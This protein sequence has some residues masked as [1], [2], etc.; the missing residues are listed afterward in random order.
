MTDTATPLINHPFRPLVGER[1]NYCVHR[2]NEFD[3]D[4]GEPYER[5]I[6]SVMWNGVHRIGTLP[7]QS[8]PI[9]TLHQKKV[10][11]RMIRIDGPFE[12][13]TKEGRLKCLDGWLAVD[14]AGFPYPISASDYDDMYEPVND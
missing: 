7:K 8:D 6:K 9:W 11:T 4:C 12:V 10:P 1:E 5:H 2:D 3:L 14:S 13:E